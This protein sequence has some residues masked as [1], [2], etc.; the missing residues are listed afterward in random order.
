MPASRSD[1]PD[2]RASLAPWE[3]PPPQPRLERGAVHVWRA[4]LALVPP[5]LSDRLS[6]QEHARAGRFRRPRDGRLWAS[7]RAVL[8]SLLAGYLGSDAKALNIAAD[9]NGKLSL[10][11]DPTRTPT[12]ATGALPGSDRLSFN[13]SHSAGIALFAFTTAGPVGVDIELARR[14]IDVLA[15]AARAFGAGAA[16]RLARLDAAAREREFLRL[17]VRH[18]AALKCLGSGLGGEDMSA[19]DAGAAGTAAPPWVGEL[20]IGARAAGAVALGSP[21][22]ELRCWE[23]RAVW[24]GRSPPAWSG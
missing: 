23:W 12:T 22:S 2:S 17:W 19:A 16:G 3:D 14:P 7:S 10:L 8:R 6:R 20:E 13:L 21:P 9:A 11:E 4:D 1:R 18:E 5:A 15:L 24:P